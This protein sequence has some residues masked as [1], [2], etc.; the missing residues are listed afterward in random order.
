MRISTRY[1]YES[2]QTD[3]RNAQERL[4]K[5]SE[6]LSTGKRINQL[7]DDPVGIRQSIGMRSLRSS[8]D[9]YKKNL[10]SAK[11]Q[12]GYVDST[13]SEIGDLM[14]QAY[15][16]AVQGASSA[17]DQGGRVAMAS[18]IESL[19]SRLIE[20]ANTKGP[21]GGYLFSGQKSST[22]PYV[23]MGTNLVFNGDTNATHVETGPGETLQTNVPTEPM[24][25]D[26][27][28]RLESLKSNLIGGQV[29]A[30]SGVD[31]A[32][33]QDSQKQI[34]SLR[35][36]VGAR[37]Q[38]VD[39]LKLQWQRRRDEL[40]INIS[41]VEDVDFSEAAVQYQQANQAYNAALT[42]ASQGFRLSLMDFI[43]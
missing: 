14:L 8:M 12:L 28:N 15:Q 21:D 36:T 24:F 16:S 26:M 35:G 30:I 22:K 41:D 2:F 7:S 40:T 39:D 1:Q 10:N 13:A 11:G 34:S 6:Q 32:A 29:G 23:L 31:I 4:S 27:Y 25:T 9:Q 43:K 38:K 3:I 18:R 37:L 42:V 33:I 17:T 20:L 5:I 19:Q